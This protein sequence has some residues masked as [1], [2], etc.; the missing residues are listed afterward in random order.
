M[1]LPHDLNKPILKLTDKDY[2]DW[3]LGELLALYGS[4]YNVNIKIFND[5][6]HTITGWLEAS[7]TPTTH[8]VPNV[9][10]PTPSA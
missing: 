7:P 10:I 1:A 6:Q 2:N 8:I 9:P 4:A 3:G 5:L